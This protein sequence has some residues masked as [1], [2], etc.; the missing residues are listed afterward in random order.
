MYSQQ[1][2]SVY[3]SQFVVDDD[4][5]IGEDIVTPYAIRNVTNMPIYVFTLVNGEH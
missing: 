2:E 4:E 1:Q 3:H 5:D